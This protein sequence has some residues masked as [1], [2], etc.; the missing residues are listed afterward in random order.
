MQRRNF[1]KG[2][3]VAIAATATASVPMSAKENDDIFALGDIAFRCEGNKDMRFL[4]KGSWLDNEMNEILEKKSCC[5]TYPEL[6]ELDRRIGHML[7]E[8]CK[9]HPENK[10]ITIDAVIKKEDEK[11]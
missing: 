1:L 10:Q 3:F 9:S 4:K 5:V 7:Y 2:I 11:Q 6:T 8:S